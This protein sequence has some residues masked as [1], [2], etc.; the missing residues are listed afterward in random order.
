MSEF[1]GAA[2]R[3]LMVGFVV[4]IVAPLC[5]RRGGRTARFLLF[6]GL[7]LAVL[8]VVTAVVLIHEGPRYRAEEEARQRRHA[9]HLAA[10]EVPIAKSVLHLVPAC[11]QLPLGKKKLQ[12]GTEALGEYTPGYWTSPGPVKLWGAPLVW[13]QAENEPVDL[14]WRLRDL[15]GVGQDTPLART[16][17]DPSGGP[18]TVFVITRIWRKP[19]GSG[20][21]HMKGGLHTWTE[22]GYEDFMDVCVLY[23]PAK[24][25][26]GRLRISD[27]SEQ[28]ED[29]A[30]QERV[31]S[32]PLLSL[33]EVIKQLPQRAGGG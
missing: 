24:K 17:A 27:G 3:W 21:W 4:A 31:L 8:V 13:W 9:E 1:E 23:W 20:K 26:A 7:T 33:A 25:V 2:F 16:T 28:T 12:I 5:W 10:V 30:E 6:C 29:Q 11:G 19:T 14:D 15:P 22:Y 32:Y 18:V